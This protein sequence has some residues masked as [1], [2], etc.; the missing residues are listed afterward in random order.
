MYYN[1]YIDSIFFIQLVMNLYL[2]SITGKILKCT[3]T[4]RRI[5]L[6]ALFGAGMICLVILLPVCNLRIRLFCGMIP[7][8]MCMMRIVYPIRSVKNVF[9]SSLIMGMS[10]FFFG[11]IVSWLEQRIGA[12]WN[13]G[14]RSDY[15]IWYLLFYGYIGYSLLK[16][17]IHKIEKRKRNDIREIKIPVKEKEVRIKA[18]VDTG[19][20][21]TE[22]MSGAPVCIMSEGAAQ[23]V[24]E[25]FL[26]ENFH[27]IP[28]RSV[29]KKRGIL[30]AYELPE[31]IIE[32]T[33]QE[34]HRRKV[35]VAICNAGISKDSVYQMILH[36]QLL[37]D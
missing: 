25:C 27:V 16:V 29:G 34:I 7:V 15:S 1:L 6:G 28:Y 10:G 19:N 24:Q 3:A 11:S 30:E 33:Y 37:D 17:L 2:L 21:L 32:D 20:H 36:P 23:N 4:H 12:F 13:A 22:P 5:L 26:P 35:I 8:S 31:L 9:Q 14:K 18:L